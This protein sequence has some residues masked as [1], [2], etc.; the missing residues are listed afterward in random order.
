MVIF[1]N[2]FATQTAHVLVFLGR[3]EGEIPLKIIT[4]YLHQV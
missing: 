3:G 1:E 2:K 4:V